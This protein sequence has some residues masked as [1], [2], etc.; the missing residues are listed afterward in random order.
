MGSPSDDLDADAIEHSGQGDVWLKD[1]DPNL[2]SLVDVLEDVVCDI[3]GDALDEVP[4][5]A[6]NGSPGG[7]EDADVVEGVVEVVRGAGARQVG[8]DVDVDEKLLAQG[9]LRGVHAV[10]A[11]QTQAA[12]QELV[13]GGH[14]GTE[15]GAAVAGRR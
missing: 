1:A 8:R 5:V 7:F 4:G 12:Q 6:L 9:V 13:G 14:R 2:G 10:A 11:V 3:G 15:V